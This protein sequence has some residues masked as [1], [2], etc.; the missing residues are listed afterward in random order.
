[1][2]TNPNQP[3][4]SSPSQPAKRFSPFDA[5]D[6]E[7]L[8]RASQHKYDKLREL[9]LS[10]GEVLVAYSG[11]CDSAFLTRVAHDVLGPKAVAMTAVGPALAPGE[12]E[13]ATELADT[14][15][16][17]H[18]QVNSYEMEREGYRANASDRCY[19]CKSELYDLALAE[20][21]KRG[22]RVVLS[23]TNADELKDYRPGLQAASEH[24]VLHPMAEAGLSK[25]EIRAWSR[26]FDLPTWEK[27][28][29]PCLSSR[30]PYG[31]QVTPE[32]LRMIGQAEVA[33]RKAGL[34]IFRVRH[35]E[36][37]A[38]IEVSEQEMPKLLDPEVRRQ[39]QQGVLAAGYTFVVL[40]LEPFRTGRLNEAAGLVRLA[41]K[42]GS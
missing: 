17:T 14:L 39:I 22:I 31:T 3:E 36:P 28:Q 4:N 18:L 27:P 11:G 26:K 16:V 23:G 25:T 6:W 34:K 15:G 40:D 41:S 9:L 42:K 37:I 12:L 32:R 38:R 7:A 2:P 1:M 10:Y 19:H 8:T 21:K 29:A 33:I 20:A 24:G 35:H 13:A 30:L 5:L